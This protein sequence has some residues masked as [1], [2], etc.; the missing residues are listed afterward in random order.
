MS[1]LLTAEAE[2]QAANEET[3]S[4]S[5][6]VASIT[7]RSRGDSTPATLLATRLMEIF[8]FDKPEKVVAEYPCWLLQSVLLQGYL[9]ITR[10]HICF[11]AYLPKKSNTIAKNGYLAK[12]GRSNMRYNRYWFILK[13]DVLS[14]YA[15]PKEQ[16]FLQGNID[17]RYGISASLSADK[18]AH[19]DCKDF[20][21]TTDHRTY[22]FRAD[23]PASAKEWVQILQKTIFR[24]HNDGDSVKISLPIEN[25]IDI[26]KSTV[27]EFAE[28]IKIRVIEND[29]S[30][31]MDEV[32]AQ[33]A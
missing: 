18:D 10:Y 30:Y 11:Y 28:T 17:L 25:V 21:V 16:Y 20:S 4:P 3:G 5:A 15:T 13:G 12:R 29:E 6:D 32:S 33:S 23:S 14:Y 7:T 22:H 8:G 9:Y 31:A 19:K 1:R 26:E 27:V 24:S 2:F